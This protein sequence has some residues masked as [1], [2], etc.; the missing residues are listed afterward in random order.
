MEDR[1]HTLSQAV[2]QRPTINHRHYDD[3]ISWDQISKFTLDGLENLYRRHAQVTWHVLESFMARSKPKNRVKVVRRA[4]RPAHIV[5]T[6][7][8]CTWLASADKYT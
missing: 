8:E 6:H 5:R 7:C 2:A 4:Y 1:E 3:T